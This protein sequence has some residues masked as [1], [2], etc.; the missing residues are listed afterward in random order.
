MRAAWKR[1]GSSFRH[2]EATHAHKP[3][4]HAPRLYNALK[5]PWKTQATVRRIVDTV[6]G[7]GPSGLPG[8]DDLG[9]MSA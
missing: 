5:Q 1:S 2:R 9:T 8:N 7:T 6:Y 3:G 4:I